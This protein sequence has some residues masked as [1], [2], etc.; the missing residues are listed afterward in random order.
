M[1]KVS[2]LVCLIF[3]IG[4]ASA[5]MLT[6]KPMTQ[7]NQETEFRIDQEDAGFVITIYYSKYQ[8]W[9]QSGVIYTACKS[10][11]TSIAYEHADKLKKKIKPIN[12]QRIRFD[13]GRNSLSGVSSCSATVKVEFDQ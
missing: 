10:T 2:F 8:F 11:I 12:E 3:F 5:T 6:D 1:K 13:M 9:P 4:C 7:Y